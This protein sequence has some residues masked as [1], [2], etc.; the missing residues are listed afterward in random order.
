MSLLRPHISKSFVNHAHA[1]TDDKWPH[2]HKIDI[3]LDYSQ[4]SSCRL[5]L[6]FEIQPVSE[7]TEE[8]K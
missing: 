7:G 6:P 4:E 2:A 1:R 8:I 3:H 5:P